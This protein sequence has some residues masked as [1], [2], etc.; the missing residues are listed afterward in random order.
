MR[1]RLIIPTTA[2]AALSILGFSAA[3]AF[4]DS[5][6][7]GTDLGGPPAVI[8]NQGQSYTE[9]ECSPTENYDTTS[10]RLARRIPVVRMSTSRRVHHSITRMMHRQL[11]PNWFMD[12]APVLA[13][14]VT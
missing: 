11:T 10:A 1:Y 6:G 14:C 5:A 7:F 2:M 13:P 3:P 12:T 9:P 4:A 8:Q